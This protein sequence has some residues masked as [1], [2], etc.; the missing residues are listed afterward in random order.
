MEAKGLPRLALGMINHSLS[1]CLQEA[2]VSLKQICLSSYVTQ[3]QHLS[4]ANR[5]SVSNWFYG[6]YT[7]RGKERQSLENNPILALTG[8]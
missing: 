4:S 2:R 7:C 6:K 8:Q 5:V 3:M 1:L